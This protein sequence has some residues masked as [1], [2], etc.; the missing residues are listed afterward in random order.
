MFIYGLSDM[1][2]L[3]GEEDKR[4]LVEWY[5]SRDS[6][7]RSYEKPRDNYS[8][9]MSDPLRSLKRKMK[10]CKADNERIIQS[11]EKL[12]REHEKKA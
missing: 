10:S 12:A 1:V 4:C 9:D 5:S 11:Q 3:Q 6:P 2:C 7:Y 8:P